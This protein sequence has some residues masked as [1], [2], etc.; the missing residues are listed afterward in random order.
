MQLV[1]ENVSCARGG[2]RILAG[3]SFAVSGGEALLV[4]GRNGAGKT[5]LLRVLAG[6][7]A[8]TAGRVAVAGSDRGVSQ[9]EQCHFIGHANAVKAAMTVGE[10]LRFWGRF[11]AGS[12]AAVPA[13]LE[14]FGLADL[15][16]VP[17]GELSAGQQRRLSLARLLV[18]S[19]PVWLLDEPSVSL[20]AAALARLLG[21]IA[22]HLA[23]G[24]LAVI[25]THVDLAV[26]NARTLRLDTA[27]GLAA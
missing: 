8:P 7:G 5:T 11:L 18:A 14:H 1:A 16:E 22:S 24:G 21:V 12:E 10:N 4:R 6:L 3:L 27:S 23:G 19:R 15:D 25:A 13:A 26:P 17:A 9:A 2:R 20:D